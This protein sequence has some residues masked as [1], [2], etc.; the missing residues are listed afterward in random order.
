MEPGSLEM[1]DK[2]S[3][4]PPA[5]EIPL[6]RA[7]QPTVEEVPAS[8]PGPTSQSKMAE[9]VTRDRILKL[10]SD[11]EVAKVSTAETALHLSEGDEY[12]DLCRLDQGVSYADG[13]AIPI[14]NVLPRKAVLAETWLNILTQLD[15]GMPSLRLRS[16]VG[17]VA[18]SE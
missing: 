14:R 9:Y 10:L 13:I 6:E 7:S 5:K 15:A 2:E 17:H 4:P 3:A 12:I 16:N 11:D 1:F 18:P 8:A